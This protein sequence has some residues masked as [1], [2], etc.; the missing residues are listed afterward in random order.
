M[1]L[2]AIFNVIGIL[3]IMHA[4][5]LIP[6]IG[7][8]YF[9]HQPPI[10][11]Y[12]SEIQAFSTTF[13]LSLVIGLAL[14]RVLPSGVETL[15]DREG[16]AIVSFAWILI[17]LFGALPF[18]MTGV[19]HSFVDAYFESISGFTTTGASIFKDIDPL[20]KGILFWRSLIQ[21]VGGMGIIM[22]SLAIFP[23]LGIGSFHLFKAEVPGGATVERV[24]PRLAETAKILW[25]VYLVLTVVQIIL[26]LTAGVSLYNAVCH[27]FS[28]MSTG[29]FSTYTASAGAF[30]NVYVEIIIIVFMLLAGANFAVHYQWIH[31]N[32]QVAYKNPEMR[33]YAMFII[34]A[35]AITT[36]GLWKYMPNNDFLSAL[37][38]ASFQVVTLNTT[39][40]FVT[41]DF[42]LWPEFLRF[43]M[44]L[45]MIVGGSSAS[46]SGGLKSIRII[47]LYKVIGREFQKIIRPRGIF[48]V[49]V[50]QKTVDPDQ[51]SNVIGLATLFLGIFLLS[52]L[53]LTFM[54]V[55]IVTS[56]SAVLATLFN[57]GPGLG[58][59][60]ATGSFADVPYWGKWVLIFCM[61]LGR[62][63]VYG[64]MLLF[65]P[66][67]WRK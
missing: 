5:I 34:C 33:F 65:L 23:F 49:K 3:L 43:L 26:L 42:N 2:K 27:T 4:G 61:L 47:I 63:E 67:T 10:H 59:V 32:F 54:E 62:L 66:F 46:T 56:I 37:R 13:T 22:L 52:S 21:W 6:P 44:L 41:D 8:A 57:V 28:T 36:F 24:Q 64:I 15:R 51:I 16:F 50:G 14:W 35:T 12:F 9:F 38:K 40:G 30:K 18:Y 48:L 60:G 25:K 55:D 58:M 19:C 7:V 39:T 17:S 20:P 31:G 53:L 45:L 11:G 1:N 29:G